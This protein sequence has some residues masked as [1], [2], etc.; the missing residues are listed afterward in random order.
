MTTCGKPLHHKLRPPNN[1]LEP[2]TCNLLCLL[3]CS[4]PPKTQRRTGT[5]NKD[6]LHVPQV[7]WE[8]GLDERRLMVEISSKGEV[9]GVR[10]W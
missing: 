5:L 6:Q 9:L 8:I 1:K 3:L 7:T 10:G 4:F 2:R